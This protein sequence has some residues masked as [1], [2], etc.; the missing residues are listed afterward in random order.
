M[1]MSQ[2]TKEQWITAII[3]MLLAV[4]N[5]WGVPAAQSLLNSALDAAGDVPELAALFNMFSGKTEADKAQ[6]L[7]D[8]PGVCLPLAQDATECHTAE[9][10]RDAN[11]NSVADKDEK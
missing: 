5:K 10:W 3:A 1:T 4:I 11:C 8:I 9:G 7:I 2:S 6:L